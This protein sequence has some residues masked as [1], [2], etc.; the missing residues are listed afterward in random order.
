MA[1]AI[2]SKR[3]RTVHGLAARLALARHLAIGMGTLLA[4]QIGLRGHL[5]HAAA[6]IL[7]VSG[8]MAARAIS[9]PL[10]LTVH[11]LAA[12]RL[13]A[14]L[15]FVCMRTG[16]AIVYGW[17]ADRIDAASLILMI[18]VCISAFI[19]FAPGTHTVYGL[20]T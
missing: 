13:G 19:I 11:R 14:L 5:V 2:L 4:I 9:A 12:T 8:H 20:R 3:T 15:Q 1:L 17:L 7:M 18:L 10:A 6:L 16:I